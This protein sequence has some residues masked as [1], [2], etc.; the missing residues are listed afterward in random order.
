MAKDSPK[1]DIVLSSQG[2]SFP[3]V[4]LSLK[5]TPHTD[6]QGRKHILIIGGGVSGLMTAW[7]LLDKG[8]RV[9][10]VAEQWAWT[11]DWQESRLTS[12]IAGALWEFPPGG[13]CGASEIAE[14]ADPESW[15]TIQ[16]YREWALQS[17]EFYEKFSNLHNAKYTVEFGGSITKLHSFFYNSLTSAGDVN[18]ADR[19]KHTEIRTQFKNKRIDGFETGLKDILPKTNVAESWQK[20]LKDAYTHDA[21]IINTDR[22]MEF[23]MSLL[24]NKGAEMETRKII[25]PLGTTGW[26]LQSEYGADAIVH[27]TG[28][29]ARDLANDP[30]VFPVLGAI[31]RIE[32]T[33][34]EN[35]LHISDAYLVPFQIGEDKE[36]IK[37][38]SLVPRN[39]ETL[40]VGSIFQPELSLSDTSPEV[41]IMWNQARSFLPALNDTKP[42]PEYPFAQGLRPFTKKNVKVRAEKFEKVN[43]ENELSYL[44]IVHNYGH[45]GSGWT[46][47][48]GCARTAV[49]LLEKILLE[50]ELA[51]EVNRLIY[52]FPPK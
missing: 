9:T 30:D 17:Y 1:D 27:A 32:N 46:L 13:C 25:G 42:R 10:I 51:E 28:L 14:P 22:A 48:V 39:D 34:D 7:I 44:N 38:I 23:L 19:E 20:K 12:Q 29:G 5:P 31:K 11:K 3:E 40:I 8:Y 15:A 4:K 16:H 18:R 6:Q 47:A 52:P 37:P 36:P 2:P 33:D 21:P 35:F 49:F 50:G 24:R 26:D 43:T 45:G 41:K